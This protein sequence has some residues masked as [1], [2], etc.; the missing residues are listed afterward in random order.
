[1]KYK[2]I[3]SAA[4]AAALIGT[5]GIFAADVKASDKAENAGIYTE[6]FDDENYTVTL[7]ANG[8]FM[9]QGYVNTVASA[10]FTTRKG[11]IKLPLPYRDSDYEFVG[12]FTEDGEK[13]SSD[14]VYHSDTTLTAKW[15]ITG[16]RTL[17]FATE[18]GSYIRPVTAEY[19]SVIRLTDYIP[20]RAGYIFSGWYTD[21][22]TKEN[23]VISVELTDDETV[24]AKW[25]PTVKADSGYMHKDIVYMTEDEI[26]LNT[27]TVKKQAETPELQMLRWNRIIQLIRQI[28]SIS[29]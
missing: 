9:G 14:K 29:E 24:Y 13:V 11:Q 27:E 6:M 25:I 1:M 7:D 16:T 3:I 21:P 8:G 4:M 22:Q 5:S 2:R 26:R 28:Y 23:K 12:W 20:T 19:G 17:T 15:R 10:T 18:D